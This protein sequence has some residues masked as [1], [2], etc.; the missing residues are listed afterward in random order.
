MRKGTYMMEFQKTS[1]TC[2]NMDP[3]LVE[4]GDSSDPPP[5]PGA[6][7]TDPTACQRTGETWSE[8]NCTLETKTFC[9][10]KGTA[11]SWSLIMI[12]RQVTEDASRLEGTAD[13][14]V[15]SACTGKY[16]LT[17]TRR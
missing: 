4:L 11:Q 16:T 14:I 15:S 3:F 17:A 8:G 13:L 5:T 2:L 1:G 12:S 6:A 10:A 7:A 9:P